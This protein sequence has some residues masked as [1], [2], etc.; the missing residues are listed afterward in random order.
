MVSR[1]A[2]TSLR[3]ESPRTTS[4]TMKVMP[5]SSPTSWTVAVFGWLNAAASR[6][7]WWNRARRS[8]SEV[9]SAGRTLMATLRLSRV[10]V[11]W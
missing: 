5:S 11:A 4:M 2:R 1:S 10:S 6:A 3:S 9:T 7:S 8:G